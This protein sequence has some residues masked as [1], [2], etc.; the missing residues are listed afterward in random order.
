[1][2]VCVCDND[3]FCFVTFFIHCIYTHLHTQVVES[4]TKSIIPSDTV[5]TAEGELGE[6]FYVVYSGELLR[7]RWV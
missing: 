6:N 4:M 3:H 7:T 2:C 1:V 5:I